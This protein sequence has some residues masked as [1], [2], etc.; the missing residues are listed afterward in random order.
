MVFIPSLLT[1]SVLL[2]AALRTLAWRMLTS[3]WKNG[4]AFGRMR[5]PK[6]TGAFSFVRGRL[7]L[8]RRNITK[9]CERMATQVRLNEECT[10]NAHFIALTLNCW[11]YQLSFIL[12]LNNQQLGNNQQG[13]ILEVVNFWAIG[14]SYTVLIEDQW[15]IRRHNFLQM[16]GQKTGQ[17]IGVSVF[18]C[19]FLIFR[20]TFIYNKT[21]VTAKIKSFN[22]VV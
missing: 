10:L 17:M 13:R 22:I 16:R 5:S 8:I 18:I 1:N 19:F 6:G 7:D 15:L 9:I 3:A 11:F 20:K 2:L 14:I 12:R 4:E 21:I